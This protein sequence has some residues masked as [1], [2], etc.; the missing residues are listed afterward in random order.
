MKV[1]LGSSDRYSGTALLEMEL[2]GNPISLEDFYVL[3]NSVE[4]SWA[5]SNLWALE[6]HCNSVQFSAYEKR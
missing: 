3:Q 6:V 5:G 2:C 1:A 4:K